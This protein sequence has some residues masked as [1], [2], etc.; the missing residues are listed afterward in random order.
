MSE[1]KPKLTEEQKKAKFGDAYDPE[2]A[3]RRRGSGNS[4]RNQAPTKPEMPTK[5]DYTYYVINEELGK[6]TAN[7]P[8]NQIPGNVY[9]SKFTTAASSSGTVAETERV[10]R[11]ANQA[12]MAIRYA[13][14]FGYGQAESDAINVAAR[15]LYSFVRHANSGAKNYESPDLMMYVLALS[16]I[17]AEYFE[18]QRVLDTVRTFVADNRAIPA[19]LLQAMGIS[20]TVNEISGNLANYQAQL[21]LIATKI[22]TFALPKYFKLLYRKIY[23]SSRVFVDSTSSRSQYYVLVRGGCYKWSPTAVE[24]GTSLQY[25]VYSQSTDIKSKIANLVSMLD[26]MYT[27]QDASTMSGDILKAF[28]D[29]E[30]YGIVPAT[31]NK[32]LDLNMD[33]D[34]LAQIEN[35]RLVGDHYGLTESMISSYLNVTQDANSN[36]IQSGVRISLASMAIGSAAAIL[37]QEYPYNSHKDSPDWKD[38]IEWTRLMCALTIDAKGTTPATTYYA[39]QGGLEIPTQITMYSPVSQQILSTLV[40][41][42]KQT[43]IEALTMCE[44]AQFDWHPCVIAYNIGTSQSTRY[45]GFDVKVN[46]WINYT[47]LKAMHQMANEAVVWEENLY[48]RAR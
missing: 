47:T 44:L 39:L 42:Q 11:K 35:L 32:M 26:A 17:Y 40:T 6:L 10:E 33:E 16:D 41:P 38:N 14:Y 20:D 18:C 4:S 34:I 27:D 21:N 9:T 22:N 43:T 3:K 7:L 37:M 24:T 36:I 25:T 2:F 12:I 29:A 8:F 19:Y 15:Q 46:T 45:E 30:L 13:P 28:S 1:R 31:S 5:N 48:K 23:V